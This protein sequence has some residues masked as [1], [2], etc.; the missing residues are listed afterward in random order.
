MITTEE[1]R[2]RRI[3]WVAQ[4]L[5]ETRLNG[6]QR[7]KRDTEYA[8]AEAVEELRAGEACAL[9]HGVHRSAYRSARRGGEYVRDAL[10][11]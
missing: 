10:R 4:W 7:G 5:K 9:E 1:T 6:G 11:L 3:W 2:I 8:H